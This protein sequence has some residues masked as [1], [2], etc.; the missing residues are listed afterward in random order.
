[1]K[2]KLLGEGNNIFNIYLINSTD[3][4]KY[5]LPA[6]RSKQAGTRAT[7]D[8]ERCR[9]LRRLSTGR[10]VHWWQVERRLSRC[11]KEITTWAQEHFRKLLSANI[12]NVQRD[13]SCFCLLHT[14]SQIFF[15]VLMRI[16]VC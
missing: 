4:S 14:S 11:I 5:M 8:R 7:K 13:A 1:M 16:N 6:A 3:F 9:K 2:T 12:V 15:E 10:Q